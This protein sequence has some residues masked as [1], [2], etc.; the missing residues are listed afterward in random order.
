MP[1]LLSISS[2]TLSG[3]V[4]KGTS[5]RG[6]AS[7]KLPNK[8]AIKLTTAQENAFTRAL[9]CKLSDARVITILSRLSQSGNVIVKFR[10]EIRE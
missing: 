9:L 1:A 5:S 4:M 10:G 2:V 6:W 3:E 8:A 7:A